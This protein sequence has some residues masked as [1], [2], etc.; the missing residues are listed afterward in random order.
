MKIKMNVVHNK[1]RKLI[2]LLKAATNMRTEK[3]ITSLINIRNSYKIMSVYC[4]YYNL[5]TPL[6][7]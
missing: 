4:P 5:F 2:S 6:P 7:I 1:L 3:M